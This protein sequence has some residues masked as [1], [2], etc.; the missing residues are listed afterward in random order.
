MLAEMIPW[1][2]FEGFLK[3]KIFGLRGNSFVTYG[4]GVRDLLLPMYESKCRSPPSTCEI[5]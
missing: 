2:L 3:V 4:G 5:G 1:N